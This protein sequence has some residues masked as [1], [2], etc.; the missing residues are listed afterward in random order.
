MHVDYRHVRQLHDA[1]ALGA[2]LRPAA[3]V[4]AEAVGRQ[5]D[6]LPRRSVKNSQP[7]EP[8]RRLHFKN[9]P[10]NSAG[11]LIDQTG[12]K[13]E[14]V[15]DAGV[16]PIHANFIVNRG[17]ATSAI[18]SLSFAGSA[19]ASTPSTLFTLS[20]KFCFTGRTGKTCFDH[21]YGRPASLSSCHLPPSLRSSPAAL[22]PSAKSPSAPVSPAPVRSRARSRL[23]SSNSRPMPCR[24]A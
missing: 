11:R 4:D 15:G 2:L 10:G 17:Q 22:P 8:K 3:H 7:R 14:R 9:P 13:G 24:P 23:H 12:L 18:S 6:A 16:S 20:R 19:R 1:I 21:G 5:I